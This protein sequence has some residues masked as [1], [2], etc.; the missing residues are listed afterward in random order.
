MKVRVVWIKSALTL[1]LSRRAGE[2]I[3]P[4]KRESDKSRSSRF[5]IT[6]HGHEPCFQSNP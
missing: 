2:G 5:T 4:D 3:I 1:S 6:S